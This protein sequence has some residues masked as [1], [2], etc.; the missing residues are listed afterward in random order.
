MRPAE[1]LTPIVSRFDV[2]ELR[3]LV[4]I[5]FRLG[6][7]AIEHHYEVPLILVRPLLA[8]LEHAL[9]T[10]PR[11]YPE[12]AARFVDDEPPRCPSCSGD[13]S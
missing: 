9:L 10:H 12:S 7:G 8:V 11:R 13:P 3:D 4:C 6:P 5:V 1:S 2:D